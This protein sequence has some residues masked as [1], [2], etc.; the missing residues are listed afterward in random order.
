MK[1]TNMRQFLRG[2]AAVITFTVMFSVVAMAQHDPGCLTNAIGNQ[3]AATKSA[4]SGWTGEVAPANSEQ[5]IALDIYQKMLLDRVSTYFKS[6]QNLKGSFIQTDADNKRMKGNFFIKQPGRFRFDYAL[7]SRQ[8]IISDGQNIAIQD[9]DLN[10]EDRVSLGQT[11]F[12]LFLRRDVNLARDA[13]ILEVKQLPDLIVLTFG[14]KDQS[15]LGHIKLFL[16]TKPSMELKGWVMTDAQ[17]SDTKVHLS[18]TAKDDDISGNL[19]K[20]QAL[21]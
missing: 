13:K 18:Q 20:I 1:G 6:L 8:I 12:R 19:F 3:P 7:P 10:N 15:S 17:G 5:G 9:C 2:T 21:W 4:M 16:A 14:D 11:P